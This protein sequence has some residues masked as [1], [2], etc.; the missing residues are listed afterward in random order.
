V[1]STP[2][3]GP[4]PDPTRNYWELLPAFA[5]VHS[6]MVLYT[7]TRLAGWL[8]PLSCLAYL[9]PSTS[10]LKNPHKVKYKVQRRLSVISSK[11]RGTSFCISAYGGQTFQTF[12]ARMETVPSFVDFGTKAISSSGNFHEPQNFLLSLHHVVCTDT[13]HS[14]NL[15]ARLEQIFTRTRIA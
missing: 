10:A 1:R 6:P 3:R 9:A 5:S 7:F 4:H 12:V 14:V 8:G 15:V 2:G 11:Q 13:T